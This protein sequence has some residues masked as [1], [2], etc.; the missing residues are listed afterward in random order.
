MAGRALALVV[1]LA[2]VAGCSVAEVPDATGTPEP[3]PL[4]EGYA[5]DGVDADVAIATHRERAVESGSVTVARRLQSFERPDSVQSTDLNFTAG[6]EWHVDFEAGAY[7][8]RA[9]T[10]S[11]QVAYAPSDE[12]WVFTYTPAREGTT[13]S[14]YGMK[15]PRP[16]VTELPN[17]DMGHVSLG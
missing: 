3:K 10:T 17:A 11:V 6:I 9:N 5:T 12:E 1:L 14:P 15:R 2:L 16:N 7:W 8:R 13:I 4:P